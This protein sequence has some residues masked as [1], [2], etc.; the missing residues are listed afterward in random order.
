MPSL[1]YILGMVVA[2]GV[3][4]E[5]ARRG[6][7]R[8]VLRTVGTMAVGTAIIYAF[9]VP[10]LAWDTGMTAAQAVDAGLTPFL[11]GDALKAALAMGALPAAWH[12]AGRRG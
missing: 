3:V 1:G 10:Y 7:D 6:G 9:G 12:L 11:F 8:T 5:L 4:G 2:A